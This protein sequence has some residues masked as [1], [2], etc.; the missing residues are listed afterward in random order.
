M[1]RLY[2]F[3]N[4]IKENNSYLEKTIKILINQSIIEEVQKIYDDWQ[5]DE[6]GIDDILGSGGICDEIANKMVDIF[7]NNG[8]NAFTLYDPHETHTSAY[9]YSTKSKT[10]YNVDI[11][12]SFYEKGYL[13][14]WTKIPNVVFNENMVSITEVD[15]DTYIDENGNVKNFDY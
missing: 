6:D 1:K 7:T 14:T 9:V 15:Y 11:P 12:Y 13:Y 8:L 4:F 10:C 3:Y 5:Q 2:N